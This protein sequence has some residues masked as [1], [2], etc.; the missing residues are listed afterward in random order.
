[1]RGG[2]NHVTALGVVGFLL[3]R[4]C[5]SEM[6]PQ[7]APT[8]ARASFLSLSQPRGAISRGRAPAPCPPLGLR[9]AGGCRSP[10]EAFGHPPGTTKARAPPAAKGPHHR[11]LCPAG[12]PGTQCCSLLFLFFFK[13]LIFIFPPFF[14]L[15]TEGSSGEPRGC[16]CPPPARKQESLVPAFPALRRLPPAGGRRGSPG[17]TRGGSRGVEGSPGGGSAAPSP[18]THRLPRSSRSLGS[19]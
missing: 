16:V 5:C 6:Q 15:P 18:L 8:S 3:P 2:S 1:M 17:G 13:V 7:N 14:S 19:R 12:M 4:I 10:L 11:L 9:A